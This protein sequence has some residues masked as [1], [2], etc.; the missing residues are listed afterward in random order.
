MKQTC[1]S[2]FTELNNDCSWQSFWIFRPIS[3]SEPAWQF[4]GRLTWRHGCRFCQLGCCVF[5]KWCF[6]SHSFFR[7]STWCCSLFKFFCTWKI[8]T[9]TT[10]GSRYYCL[11]DGIATGNS[12]INAVHKLVVSERGLF[13]KINYCH[14]RGQQSY[15]I[16]RASFSSASASRL[17]YVS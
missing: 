8:K 9:I 5:V 13:C 4:G 12:C 10:K 11:K 17:T 14:L 15:V 3:P 7:T 1:F 2:S 6:K 16:W